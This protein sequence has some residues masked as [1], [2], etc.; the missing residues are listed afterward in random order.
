M[1]SFSTCLHIELLNSHWCIC[2]VNKFMFYILTLLKHWSWCA[3]VLKMSK[4]Y[5]SGIFC[6][7]KRISEQHVIS[8]KSFL[9]TGHT[10]SN[11]EENHYKYESSVDP[12]STSEK[13][14]AANFCPK[15]LDYK[16]HF[17]CFPRLWRWLWWQNPSGFLTDQ[18]PVIYLLHYHPSKVKALF[19]ETLNSEKDVSD[20]CTAG[21]I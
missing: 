2:W 11:A 7:V 5:F 3:T 10:T 9:F 15:S 21:E 17:V 4:L 19:F 6:R 18:N 12:T 1:C 20:F 13:L 16:N 14:K 8:P